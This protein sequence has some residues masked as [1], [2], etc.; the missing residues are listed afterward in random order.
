[1]SSTSERPTA[2]LLVA[3]TAV[4]VAV[5]V[6]SAVLLWSWRT[7]LP[8]PVARHWGADGADGFSS[9]TT[10]IVMA[11][12][13]GL[14]FAVIGA[15][16]AVTAHDRQ[17]A[18]MAIGFSTGTAVFV[19]GL[20]TVSTAGQRG[21][22]DAADAELPGA[23]LLAM[24]AVGVLAG[25]GSAAI[26]PPW[27]VSSP[28]TANATAVDP[29]TLGADER[30]AWTRSV[31]AGAA[32]VVVVVSS[33][34]VLLVIAGVTEQWWTLAIAAAILVLVVAMAS[35]RVIVDRRGVTVRSRF[36]WPRFH[37]AIA[38]IAKADVVAVKALR[39]FGGYGARLAV[40]GPH[41]GTRGVVLRSGEALRITRVDGVRELVV[42]D[43]AAT[44]AGLVNGLLQ[45]STP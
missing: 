20:I 45:R 28:D 19:V 27:R 3:S 38:D 40:I 2:R 41:R 4:P 15:L 5:T 36:G 17:A 22:A 30:A 13:M 39:D 6:A 33:L 24:V 14:M 11:V 1:M 42:V 18:R 23:W 29:V 26:I 43:D 31:G 21:L 16:L 9:L 37:T 44:A 32:G 7:D 25:V 12:I 34:A 35:V 8:D 10:V